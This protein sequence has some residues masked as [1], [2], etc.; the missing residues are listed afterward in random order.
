MTLRPP[1]PEHIN[2]QKAQAENAMPV[3]PFQITDRTSASASSPS[4]GVV[5]GI[6]FVAVMIVVV[7]LTRASGGQAT[8]ETPTAVPSP[9]PTLTPVKEIVVITAVPAPTAMVTP[10]PDCVS[11]QSQLALIEAMEHKSD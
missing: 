9:L 8:A 10:T 6:V 4:V 2:E 7:L 3:R 11:G 1:P 5:A